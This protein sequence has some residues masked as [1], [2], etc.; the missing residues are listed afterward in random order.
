MDQK[1]NKV[2][3]M[4][5]DDEKEICLSLKFML[6]FNGYAVEIFYNVESAYNYLLHNEENLPDIIITDYQM[7][8]ANGIELL[9]KVKNNYPEISVIIMTGYG[10]KKLA[11][12]SMVSGAE[13][14]L[15]KPISA[16]DVLKAIEEIINKRELKLENQRRINSTILHELNNH[17]SVLKTSVQL[18]ELED[19]SNTNISDIM[20]KQ[21]DLMNGSIR[22]M[23]TP[24]NFVNLSLKF[25]KEKINLKE[26]VDN[27]VLFLKNEAAD[28]GIKIETDLNDSWME[29][30]I[31]YIRQA[32]MNIILNAIR[33]SPESTVIKVK[34]IDESGYVCIEIADEGPGISDDLK[35]KIFNYGFRV[36]K[37][38]KGNGI[39]LFF[40]RDVLKSHNGRIEVID[41]VPKGSI[42]RITLNKN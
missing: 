2:K 31:N 42:F 5:V 28:K 35:N 14:F 9:N 27:A 10:N 13:N 38:V 21:I 34:L 20:M 25:K 26:T 12:E 8:G 1:L 39:G 29:A 6:E 11:V 41:N 40:V 37:N 30:D 32:I 15:D 16:Y 7:Q 19:K 23:L 24:E 22:T 36:N 17:L 18:I 4:V 3:I 33:Y